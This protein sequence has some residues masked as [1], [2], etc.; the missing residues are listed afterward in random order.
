MPDNEISDR[1]KQELA[2]YK[3]HIRHKDFSKIIE[4]NL[5]DFLSSVGSSLPEELGTDDKRNLSYLH[6][7][8]ANA[9]FQQPEKNFQKINQSLQSAVEAMPQGNDE[10]NNQQ[11]CFIARNYNQLGNNQCGMTQYSDA[12]CAYQRAIDAINRIPENFRQPFHQRE[13]SMYHKIYADALLQ[14]PEKDFQKINQSLQSAVEAMPQG[15]DEENNKQW[16]CIAEIYNQLGNNRFGMTQYSDAMCA[17]QQAI[18]AISKIPEEARRDCDIRLLACCY[19]NVA[20]ANNKNQD[21]KLARNYVVKS[22][23]Y[24]CQASLKDSRFY[25]DISDRINLLKTTY[26]EGTLDAQVL[27]CLQCFFSENRHHFALTAENSLNKLSKIFDSENCQITDRDILKV[28]EIVL[29]SI[30][31]SYNN[32]QFPNEPFTRLLNES[33]S[34]SKKILEKVVTNVTQLNQAS[35]S[36]QHMALPAAVLK[37]A[38]MFQKQAQQLREQEKKIIE[39]EKT[40]EKQKNTSQKSD[41]SSSPGNQSELTNFFIRKKEASNDLAA[42]KKRKGETLIPLDNKKRKKD[43]PLSPLRKKR[44]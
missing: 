24:T 6:R 2:T 5:P 33:N 39:L 7:I 43:R 34:K 27:D 22:I 8:F 9:L 15:D 31:N 17:Y 26:V 37:L 20:E 35:Q 1:L 30:Q 16:Y 21:W 25:T 32:Q 10:E 23:H 28:S 19:Y 29:T 12:I 4:S 40:I 41:A 13:L 11:W 42:N 3:E 38:T 14:Q 18:D 44:H 36:L